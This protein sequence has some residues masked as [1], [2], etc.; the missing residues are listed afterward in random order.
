MFTVVPLFIAVIGLI[1][2]SVIG[3][4]VVRALVRW[5]R[6]N[7][8]PLLT[9]PAS[10]VTK[11]GSVSGGTG[12]SSSSTTYYATFEIQGGQRL[13][14]LIAGREYGMLAER[15]RGRLSYQGTRYMGFDR[16]PQ[17]R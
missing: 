12:D 17:D 13:E 8:S 9:V 15:D 6:N 7:N 16:T 5:N 14:F 11:R 10:V 4:G 3:F 1:V 2:V